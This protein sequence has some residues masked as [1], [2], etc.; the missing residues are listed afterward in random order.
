MRMLCI[1]LIDLVHRGLIQQKLSVRSVGLEKS[2]GNKRELVE[3]GMV[4]C[5]GLR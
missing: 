3:Q 4:H 1:L 2:L 5:V